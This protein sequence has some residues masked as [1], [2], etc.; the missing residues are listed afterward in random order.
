MQTLTVQ[1]REA[2]GKSA[3][4]VRRDGS[5]PA[6]V[7]GPK[8]GSHA[9]S[10]KASD[11][12]KLYREVGE[13][14]LITLKI[15]GDDKGDSGIVLIREPKIDPVNRMFTH[16]D[17]YQLPLD[18]PIEISVPVEL[19]GEAPA[20]KELGGTLV[21]TIHEIAVKALPQ[22][23]IHEITVDVSTLATF[24]DSITVANLTVPEGIEIIAEPETTVAFVEEMKEEVEEE[25][26]NE[27]D[28][29]ADIKTEG[30]EKREEEAAEAAEGG[31]S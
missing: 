27:G 4:K 31:E 14:T 15:E 23:L 24:E 3:D 19:E 22:N 6:V 9:I 21:Q 16:V 5:I 1:P 30:E 2:L 28:A 29:I 13:T 11:F 10:V 12:E 17:F 25:A 7:Y 18:K 26:V 8:I 20:A